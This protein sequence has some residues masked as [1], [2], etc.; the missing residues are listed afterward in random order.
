LDE[1]HWAYYELQEAAVSHEYARRAA[2][3]AAENWTGP[4]GDVDFEKE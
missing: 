1:T 3:S 4:G 2:D